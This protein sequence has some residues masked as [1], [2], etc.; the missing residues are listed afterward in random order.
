MGVFRMNPR[1][2]FMMISRHIHARFNQRSLSK[3]AG[4]QKEGFIFQP[5]IFRCFYLLLASG[6][7]RWTKNVWNI[8][9]N[10]T[11]QGCHLMISESDSFKKTPEKQVIFLGSFFGY[12]FKLGHGLCW[13]IF[14]IYTL[15]TY[16]FIY[17]YPNTQLELVWYVCL[18]EWLI[19]MVHVGE[20]AI[21]WV[22]G[23]LY[24]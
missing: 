15:H 22:C 19:F 13:R 20:Y 24:P 16:V 3:Q 10:P 7:V 8:T 18:H 2:R 21:H 12:I 23:I 6:R 14:S 9:E 4:P 5:S 1:K 17:I 11:C